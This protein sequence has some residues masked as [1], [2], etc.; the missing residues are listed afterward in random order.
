MDKDVDII[1]IE[2]NDIFEETYDLLNNQLDRID[3]LNKKLEEFEI[4]KMKYESLERTYKKQEEKYKTKI[5][6]LEKEIKSIKR[7]DIEKEK[8]I[9]MLKTLLEII[10]KKYGIESISR[11]TRL[12]KEQI[13]K[14]LK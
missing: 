1:E 9:V 4:L 6:T 8:K 13:E 2:D 11:I 12:N 3:T 5:D 7:K 14:Y 10:L